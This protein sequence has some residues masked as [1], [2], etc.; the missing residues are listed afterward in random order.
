MTN[1]KIV[2]WNARPMV[3]IRPDGSAEHIPSIQRT[4]DILGV[5]DRRTFQKIVRK[6]WI[7]NGMRVIYEDDWSPTA[8]YSFRFTTQ[9]EEN[10]RR[11]RR[12][13]IQRRETRRAHYANDKRLRA[14]YVSQ[15]KTKAADPSCKF[16]KGS[17]LVPVYCL[18]DNTVYPSIKA[19]A[20]AIGCA[21][22]QISQAMKRFGRV[23]G[24][25]FV[26][27]E[28]VKDIIEYAKQDY[29]EE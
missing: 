25:K 29:H 15:A 9:E 4:M 6:R 3:L 21:K 8:D 23:R 26:R 22:A 12:A 20:E 17:P 13:D 11:Q 18:D 10:E 14:Y 7:H 2:R 28:N 19:A 24:K 5:T 27:Y 1:K 16:G